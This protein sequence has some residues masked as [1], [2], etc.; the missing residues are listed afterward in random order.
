MS[1]NRIATRYA[2]SLLDLAVENN[3]LDAVKGDVEAFIKMVENRDLY[4]LL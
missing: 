1:V 3:V 2:K 4:L